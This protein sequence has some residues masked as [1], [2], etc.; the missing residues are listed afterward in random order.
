MQEAFDELLRRAR[1]LARRAAQT[2]LVT[3]SGF[4]S[5]AEQAAV[6]QWCAQQRDVRLALFGGDAECERRVAFFLPD[7][8]PPDELVPAEQ[9]R[10]VRVDA[11]F[12]TPGHR[13][14]LGALLA[15]GVKRPWIGDIRVDG[16]TAWVFCLPSV[17]QQLCELRQAGRV[18]VR[19][20]PVPL[21]EV[22][23]PERR[24]RELSFT[25][26]SL[27]FDAAVGE[28]FRLS[29]TNAAKLITAGAASLNYLPCL[30]NDAP[31]RE[32]DVISLRGYGKGRILSVGGQS[33]KGRLFLQAELWL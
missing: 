27:R 33:R 11:A 17:A 21:E 13:D 30:K 24:R 14:Y 29:R 10:A 18:S 20:R 6:A 16:Q 2:G 26:Q 7:R 28:L 19:A 25:L 4:L 23:L 31:V 12:G 22:P 15:L 5:P 32:G 3:S 9:L 1:D 8:M